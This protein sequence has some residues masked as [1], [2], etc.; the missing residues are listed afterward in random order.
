[1]SLLILQ[2]EVKEL[3]GEANIGQVSKVASKMWRNLSSDRRM[4]KRKRLT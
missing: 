4:V 3:L 1:M 2:P